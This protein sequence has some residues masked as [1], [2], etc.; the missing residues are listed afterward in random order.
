ME[1]GRMGQK[2]KAS[3]NY[4]L[5]SEFE[6]SP[7]YVIDSEKKRKIIITKQVKAKIYRI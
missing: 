3:S 6:F 7:G 5:H 2:F 1:I 4:L